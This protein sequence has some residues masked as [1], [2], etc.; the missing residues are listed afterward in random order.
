LTVKRFVSRACF[1]G[2][3]LKGEISAGAIPA[4]LEN[5]TLSAAFSGGHG[6]AKNED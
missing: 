1:T 6:Q 5:L 4:V 3:E 2:E